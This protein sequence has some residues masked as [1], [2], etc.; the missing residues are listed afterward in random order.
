MKEVLENP[1]KILL[2][3]TIHQDLTYDFE[4]YPTGSDE[5]KKALRNLLDEINNMLM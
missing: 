4:Q 1:E 3:I 2:R 5:D